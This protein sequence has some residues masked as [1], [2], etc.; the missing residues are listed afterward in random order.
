MPQ[1]TQNYEIDI[2]LEWG[3]NE[4]LINNR[5]AEIRDAASYLKY[6]GAALEPM[7]LFKI[8]TSERDA[9]KD[10]SRII[11]EAI[12]DWHYL[13]F[14]VNGLMK[15]KQGG[16]TELFYNSKPDAVTEEKISKLASALKNSKYADSLRIMPAGIPLAK[17]EKFGEIESVLKAADE[18]L[19]FIDNLKLFLFSGKY[20]KPAYNPRKFCGR[21]DLIELSV[22]VNRKKYRTFDLTCIMKQN[23][24]NGYSR[25]EEY[26]RYRKIKGIETGECV[27]NN[28]EIIRENTVY[29]ISDLHLGHA[30]IIRTTA[31]PFA[32]RDIEDMNRVL[33]EN[34]RKTVNN[35]DRV[36]FCGDLTHKADRETVESFL[37]ELSGSITFIEGNHDKNLSGTYPNYTFE[38]GGYNFFCIHNP[39]FAPK[40]Y[41]GWIIHGHTHNTR[42]CK[43]PF[44]NM[45]R[46]TVNV[47]LELTGYRP[48]SIETIVGAI[49]KC[50]AENREK[51]YCLDDIL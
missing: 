40:N 32:D 51:V 14:A 48:V 28:R 35:G 16:I 49:E 31:R 17:S 12:C 3:F 29:F 42:M 9:L 7:K 10:I 45:K 43:Y 5:Y 8:C 24:D 21:F 39:K 18:N 2:A 15:S 25:K 36:I 20:K 50:T 13:T 37:G 1:K 22:Y 46:R 4:F 47:S 26:E 38:Y 30:N 34:W 23:N 27:S 6:N 41:A 44:I 33:I 19:S 11:L